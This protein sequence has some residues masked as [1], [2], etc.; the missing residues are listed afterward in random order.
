MKKKTIEI[1]PKFFLFIK[2]V[3]FLVIF[4]AGLLIHQM[5]ECSCVPTVVLCWFISVML[6]LA[7]VWSC[8]VV[9]GLAEIPHYHVMLSFKRKQ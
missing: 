2:V 1:G 9:A 7:Y 6:L 5:N 4:H 8:S 3:Q